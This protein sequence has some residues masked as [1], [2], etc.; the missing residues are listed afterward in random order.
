MN[1]LPTLIYTNMPKSISRMGRSYI[2]QKECAT[3]NQK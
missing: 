3:Q 2:A 1:W